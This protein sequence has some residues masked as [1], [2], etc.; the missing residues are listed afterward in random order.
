MCTVVFNI[1]QSKEI[2]KSNSLFAADH[3]L[4]SI[5]KTHTRSLW[6]LRE[7]RKNRRPLAGYNDAI[8]NQ[9]FFYTTLV[10]CINLY[11]P[12]LSLSLQFGV[13][14]VTLLQT[15]AFRLSVFILL[16]IVLEAIA[17]PLP[18]SKAL[19]DTAGLLERRSHA[20]PVAVKL[21]LKRGHYQPDGTFLSFSTGPA[22]PT[23]H[24]DDEFLMLFRRETEE[25][26]GLRAIQRHQDEGDQVLQWKLEPVYNQIIQLRLIEYP[27]YFV[28]KP[29][30]RNPSAWEDLYTA[31]MEPAEY[32]GTSWNVKELL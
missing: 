11:L 20:I 3:H 24:R 16:S 29:D 21:Y 25:G 10:R 2:C 30:P 14:M 17:T 13:I 5:S 32:T 27:T 18:M 28:Y 1:Y 26:W 23:L 22:T 8:R 9:K 15:L 4:P 19:N 6:K 7:T 12:L 31:V